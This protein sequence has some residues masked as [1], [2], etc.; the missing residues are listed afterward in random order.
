M[1]EPARPGRW[2]I[3]RPAV[4]TRLLLDTGR[5]HG[6]SADDCLAGTGLRRDDLDHPR[7][8]VLPE[9]EL[10]VIRNL[11]G[12]GADARAL[13]LETGLRYSLTSAGLL[14]YAMLSS[15]TVRE[16][17][18]LLQRFTELTSDFFDV[19]Y[20]ET[21]AG[22]LVVVG[23]GD[24][25]ADV[26][27][28]LL[29][30]DLVAGFQVASLLLSAGAR[31]LIEAMD[32][33]VRLELTD[34]G[35]VEYAMIAQALVEPFGMSIII[36]FDSPRNAFT[37]PHAFLDQ[38][39]PAPDPHTAALCVQQC[40]ELLD[41]RCRFTGTAAQVRHLLLQN[42]AAMPSLA[43]VARALGLSE[44]TLHRRLSAEHTTFRALLGQIRQLLADE[45]LAQGLTVEAVGRRLGY[46]D[47]AAFSHAYRRWHGHPPGRR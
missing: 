12:C 21:A 4:S 5:D 3:A 47:T 28:F 13:G 34:S 37:I 23:D 30:R 43:A 46:S 33:P 9:Q 1:G 22:L 31:Q 36:E 20:T 10:R 45:L 42:P 38:P 25:P 26:R 29:I 8:V 14:G 18:R 24:V 41:E 2:Q 39:T 6:L 32:D 35:P 17:I 44:R 7:A 15:S 16:A 19:S 11:L 40:A 27:P